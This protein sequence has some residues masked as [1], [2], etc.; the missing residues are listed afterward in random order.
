MSTELSYLN[1]YPLSRVTRRLRP[2]FPACRQT[3][4]E[5]L[6]RSADRRP[7]RFA[8]CIDGD[9]ERMD[10]FFEFLGSLV[11]LAVGC[12][13][14]YPLLNE[15]TDDPCLAVEKRVVTIA[16]T[17]GAN[18]RDKATLGTLFQ[19]FAISVSDGQIARA[20]AKAKNSDVPPDVACLYWYWSVT[21]NPQHVP[22]PP[23]S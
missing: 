9:R 11:V 8:S 21:L 15:S 19:Y 17:A 18:A 1:T 20:S 12:F 14:A 22:N 10:K 2:W 4:L 16:A 23:R 13:I 7:P 6:S 5:P 3:S